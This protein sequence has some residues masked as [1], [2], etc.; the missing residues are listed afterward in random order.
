MPILNF[1]HAVEI[2]DGQPKF[3]RLPVPLRRFKASGDWWILASNKHHQLLGD[4]A[5]P[6]DGRMLNRELV[7]R[8]FASGIGSTRR[9]MPS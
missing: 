4:V 5:L 1:L 7:R 3:T 2:I 9:A 8:D 6:D